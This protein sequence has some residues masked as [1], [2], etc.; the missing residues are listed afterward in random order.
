MSKKAHQENSRKLDQFYTNPEYAKALYRIIESKYELSS[1]DY[2]LEPSAGTGSFYNLMDPNKRIGLDLDPK[3]PGIIK[4]D[5]L[6]WTAPLNVN[7]I[8]IGNPPFG[9]NSSLAVKFFN[10]CSESCSVIAF[11]VPKTFRKTS[12]INRLSF[13]FHL[14]HDDDLPKNSFVYNDKPYDVPCVFQ[15]WEKKKVKR[16]VIKTY[17]FDDMKAWFTLTDPNSAHI[18]IQRVGQKAGTVKKSHFSSYSPLSHFFLKCAN[19]NVISVFDKL[20]FDAV[21]Y[22]TAGNPS[23]SASELIELWIEQARKEKLYV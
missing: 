10:K 9:K 13:H 18:C 20:N 6:T 14:I 7:M 2:I 16:D 4:Q 22:N 17:S 15:I 21:K 11:I 3:S 23:V 8:A 1:F 5:F 12:I 19:D